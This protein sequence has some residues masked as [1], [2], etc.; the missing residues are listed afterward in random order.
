MHFMDAISLLH[1]RNSAVRLRE[2]APAGEVLND[3]LKA[4]L[5]VPDH[6]LLRPWRFLTITGA[7]RNQLGELFVSSAQQR[8]E[9]A[10]EPAMSEQ[11]ATKIVSKALRAPLIIVVIAK[12]KIHQKVPEIEQI[13]SAGCAA[14]SIMLAA[15]AYGFA[16]IWRTGN[17]AYDQR[18]GLGLG[19]LVSEKIVGFLYLGSIDGNYKPL[20]ELD[21]RDFCQSWE[22]MST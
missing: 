2:P 17:N 8:L 11:L 6:A 9:D 22:T 21:V 20:R 19:L 4:G 16:G 15:H 1:S 10:G 14:H 18:V 5:R 3:M 7:A 12:I 13:I